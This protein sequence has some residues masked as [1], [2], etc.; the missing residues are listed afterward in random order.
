MSNYTD[1]ESK[2]LQELKERSIA[3]IHVKLHRTRTKRVAR[4]QRRTYCESTRRIMQT[5]NQ[6]LQGLK[7]GPNV[8]IHNE[9]HKTRFKRVLCW[10]L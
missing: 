3:K 2:V 9:L 6:E 10:K 1:Q 5:K 7:E 4:T 8:K